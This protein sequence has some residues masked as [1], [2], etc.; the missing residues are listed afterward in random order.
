LSDEVKY[1]QLEKLEDIV[2]M[3]SASVRAPPLHHKEVK[4]GHIYFL[5]ASLALGKSVIYFVKVKEEVEKKYIVLDTVHDKISFSDEL[6]TK[7][8]LQHFSIVEVTSENILP[9]EAVSS[10]DFDLR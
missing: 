4:N 1:V 9:M 7:P 10:Q 3:M 5:L 8:S 6:S 2:R